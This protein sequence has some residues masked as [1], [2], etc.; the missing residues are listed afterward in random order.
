MN[1]YIYIMITIAIIILTVVYY[2]YSKQPTVIDNPICRT[3]GGMY[4]D[5]NGICKPCP[6]NTYAG[7]GDLSCT[8]CP[9]G[10]YSSIM[11]EFCTTCN[12][13]Q[14]W[15]GT[16][17]LSC[18]P[19]QIRSINSNKCILNCPAGRVPFFNNGVTTC[20]QCAPGFYNIPGSEYCMTCPAGQSVN[21]DQS[22][23]I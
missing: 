5:S 7:I 12:S 18:D 16:T 3:I 13:N 8:H 19:G 20:E 2:L 1:I 17:C 6:E 15:G 11:S 23:C 10:S 4:T 22:G 9:S 21:S 14:Y